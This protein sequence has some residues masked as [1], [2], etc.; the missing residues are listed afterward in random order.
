MTG[1]ADDRRA[2]LLKAIHASKRKI[3][4][5]DDT[6][7][8]LLER[9]TG[10]RSSKN[11]SVREMGRVLDAMHGRAAPE[12]VAVSAAGEGGPMGAKIRALW[13][14]LWNLGVTRDNSDKALMTF[15]RRQTGRDA[16]RFLTA[17]QASQ[18]IEAL[19]A[20]AARTVDNGGGGVDWSAFPEG[21]TDPRARV[22]QAQW[23]RLYGLGWAKVGSPFALAGWLHA[24]GF[25]PNLASERRLDPRT[26][27]RAMRH[28]GGLIRRRLNEG[29]P[30]E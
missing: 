13:L 22:L 7:R 11:L 18:V 15:V 21:D 10:L 23:R 25:T 14:T 29:D 1:A 17:P 30:K 27:D 2:K 9:V 4:L 5:D 20:W 16:I 3:G 12:P 24:A 19:N 26:A 28:L 8:D 6:Y